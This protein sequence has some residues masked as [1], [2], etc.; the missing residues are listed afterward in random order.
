MEA[1]AEI[2]VP[3]RADRAGFVGG[4]LLTRHLHRAAASAR[5]RPGVLSARQPL[6]EAAA[7][8]GREEDERTGDKGV[9]RT[10]WSDRGRR[11]G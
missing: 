3:C 10:G 2:R 6:A 11:S 8:A 5:L 4:P 7:R 9:R 1:E